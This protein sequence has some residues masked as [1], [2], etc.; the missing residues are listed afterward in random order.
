MKD[1]LVQENGAVKTL[2]IGVVTCFAEEAGEA[3]CPFIATSCW[4]YWDL[5]KL[6]GTIALKTTSRNHMTSLGDD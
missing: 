2:A 1:P 6:P 3:F 5:S 4:N